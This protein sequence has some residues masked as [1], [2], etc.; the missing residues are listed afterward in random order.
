[1]RQF[2]IILHPTDF[3]AGSEAAFHYACEMARDYEARL[4]ILHTIE[5]VTQM[6]GDG[7]IIP[8]DESELYADAEQKMQEIQS[9]SP[10]VRMEK[11]HLAG[12][13]TTA[14]IETALDVKADLIVMGTHGR[15]GIG[16][17]ILGSVA[18]EVVRKAPCPVLTVKAEPVS[19]E[20][21]AAPTHAEMVTAG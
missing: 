16:R 13:P 5:P 3:S 7:I 18:E 9:S 15:T 11:I 10:G 12:S 21:A 6:V 8:Y 19:K 4:I 2:H 17:L 20:K 1:M 14:I